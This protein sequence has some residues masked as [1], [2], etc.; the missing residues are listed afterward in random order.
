MPR[1]RVISLEQQG[2]DIVTQLLFLEKMY[3]PPLASASINLSISKVEFHHVLD[4][5]DH[6]VTF[7]T[8]NCATLPS[9]TVGNEYEVSI[10]WSPDQLE[11]AQSDR[12]QWTLT[13]FIPRDAIAHQVQTTQGPGWLQR[14]VLPTDDL[15]IVDR[16]IVSGGWDHE[17][18]ELGW[19]HIGIADGYEH[20][21]Y[22]DT[23]GNWICQRCYEKYIASGFGR[24]LG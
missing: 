21:G 24:K 11:L 12:T 23:Q 9:L 7:L 13:T 19:E 8:Y 6:L 2:N 17:D 1:A 5:Q 15:H 18:C 16:I 3:S 10:W 14:P 20:Q 4:V 22:K